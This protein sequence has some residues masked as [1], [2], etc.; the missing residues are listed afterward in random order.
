MQQLI[1]AL[2][3][4]RFANGLRE[5]ASDLAAA[6]QGAGEKAR[7]PLGTSGP[8]ALFD[9]K[10]SGHVIETASLLRAADGTPA[11][12]VTFEAADDPHPRLARGTTAPPVAVPTRPSL[13]EFNAVVAG[14][15]EPPPM[16]A[17]KLRKHKAVALLVAVLLAIGIIAGIAAQ[18]KSEPDATA[19]T[20]PRS[21]H[22]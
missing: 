9:G 8:H 7:V 14:A 18:M 22:K 5:A 13:A 11:R 6:I 4:V 21:G 19:A 1:D 15:P 20:Q 2:G 16:L 12:G 3:E 10:P 17:V